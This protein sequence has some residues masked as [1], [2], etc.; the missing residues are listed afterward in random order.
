MLH[1]YYRNTYKKTNPQYIRIRTMGFLGSSVRAITMHL[2]FDDSYHRSAICNKTIHQRYMPQHTK[3][4]TH[5][6]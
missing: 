2:F 4:H 3:E 5:S 1:L 6:S